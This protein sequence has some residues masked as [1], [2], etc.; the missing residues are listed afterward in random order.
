MHSSAKDVFAILYAI[1]IEGQF[2]GG[3]DQPPADIKA[4]VLYSTVVEAQADV[5]HII[6]AWG[7]G[8]TPE[9]VKLDISVSPLQAA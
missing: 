2:Y 7:E 9:V 6:D 5:Q 8:P 1:T 4:A 3:D